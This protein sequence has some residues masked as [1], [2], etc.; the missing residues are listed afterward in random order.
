MLLYLA[1]FACFSGPGE[2]L[3][4]SFLIS[5][6]KRRQKTFPV[7]KTAFLLDDKFL[8]TSFK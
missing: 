4:L 6:K 5:C 7:R 1:L 3:L 2:F 8:L